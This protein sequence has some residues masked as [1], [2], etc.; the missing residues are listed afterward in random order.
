MLRTDRESPALACKETI[1][2][3]IEKW[4]KID[5]P[6]KSCFHAL[7]KLPPQCSLTD[8]GY[9]TDLESTVVVSKIAD[10]VRQ[11]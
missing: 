8:H 3:R 11:Y 10:T 4:V 5:E 7:I 2:K 1:D 6:H 9:V